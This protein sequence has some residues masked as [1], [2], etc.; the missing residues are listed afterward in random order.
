MIQLTG[1]ADRL[2]PAAMASVILCLALAAMAFAVAQPVLAQSA[3]EPL[4]CPVKPFQ[5]DAAA[6]KDSRFGGCVC[7]QNAGCCS[8]IDQV[9]RQST[10]G[11]AT[12]KLFKD[13]E[14]ACNLE[15][16]ECG[17]NRDE[18]RIAIRQ[19]QERLLI[20]QAC[21]PIPEKEIE[22]PLIQP[23]C[24]K[25]M[26]RLDH[27]L[28]ATLCAI[29]A[30]VQ[31]CQ[32][33]PSFPNHAARCALS[34]AEEDAFAERRRDIC[35]R[36]SEDRTQGIVYMCEIDE[37]GE[38]EASCPAAQEEFE[39]LEK[40][41]VCRK[42]AIAALKSDWTVN[43]TP[44]DLVE[45]DIQIASGHTTNVD[46]CRFVE[47]IG[48]KACTPG[49]DA[50]DTHVAPV[51]AFERARETPTDP[52]AR[53]TVFAQCLGGGCEG[54]VTL[55][56]SWPKVGAPPSEGKW[57]QPAERTFFT[58]PVCQFGAEGRGIGQARELRRMLYAR[59]NQTSF[60][61]APVNV[62]PEGRTHLIG[63]CAQ[64]PEAGAMC[65]H[66]RVRADVMEEG[67]HPGERIKVWRPFNTLAS[68]DAIPNGWGRLLETAFE[69]F[70]KPFYVVATG[71]G[72]ALLSDGQQ[73]AVGVAEG[74]AW[75]L[76]SKIG[77]FDLPWLQ[78]RLDL[79]SN[80]ARAQ[81]EWWLNRW[82]LQAAVTPS[83]D[84]PV[85]WTEGQNATVSCGIYGRSPDGQIRHPAQKMQASDRA[86]LVQLAR[87]VQMGAKER[88]R[89]RLF[90]II[91]QGRHA[92][93][94]HLSPEKPVPADVLL[95]GSIQS[96]RGRTG[97]I[98]HGVQ[99]GRCTPVETDEALP[100]DEIFVG[101]QITAHRQAFD[102]LK[103]ERVLTM[104]P[105]K[106]TSRV[107]M[108]SANDQHCD[109][110]LL[111]KPGA[112]QTAH[113]L[114]H[115]A[116]DQKWISKAPIGTAADTFLKCVRA[117]D[118]NAPPQECCLPWAT[119]GQAQGTC[120]RK[121]LVQAMVANTAIVAAPSCQ[122]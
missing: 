28:R 38:D 119:S 81:M 42:I 75:R 76:D 90:D 41:G 5:E 20:A 21:K 71:P 1:M 80:M 61:F 12:E 120:P 70:S 51:A 8:M 102:Y 110:A 6:C 10:A 33:T 29:R 31:Q 2:R 22:I 84:Q 25:L 64:D 18:F 53:V 118:T 69:A 32:I 108:L 46:A 50:Q 9:R 78:Q 121:D 54:L 73:F 100:P 65:W 122:R 36:Q 24:K 67:G 82:P 87:T 103:L 86:R 104:P 55:E 15:P 59:T 101:D 56:A 72:R 105:S 114:F 83:E 62:G 19:A 4:V 113:R 3:S 23:K 94:R 57:K 96:C 40:A 91:A 63:D 26:A 111:V 34:D 117:G 27:Q 89:A 48:G 112:W 95:Q 74:G 99:S 58:E 45:R 47:P 49:R 13:A 52:P 39:P 7:Q 68:A 30:A 116:H 85:C 16:D 107:P 37:S 106:S 60:P 109:T 97:W 17:A 66:M 92:D 44:P 14:A 93:V 98:W 88:P 79:A 115:W 11:T 43:G 35:F 77:R